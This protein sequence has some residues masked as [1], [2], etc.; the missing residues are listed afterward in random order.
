VLSQVRGDDRELASYPRIEEQD[1]EAGGRATAR[2]RWFASRRCLPA[3]LG[4]DCSAAV[5]RISPDE[6]W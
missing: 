1:L 6:Q 5:Q 3:L 4:H 2:P